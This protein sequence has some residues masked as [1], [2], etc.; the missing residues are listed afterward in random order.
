M[1]LGLVAHMNGRERSVEE[2]HKLVTEADPR[3]KIHQI[4]EQKNSMLALIEVVLE[5]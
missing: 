3:F 1:D 2:W 5:T 4:H